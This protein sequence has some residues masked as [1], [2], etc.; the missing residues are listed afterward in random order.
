VSSADDQQERLI[1]LGWVI[2]FVDG[3]GCFS[4]GVV[5]QPRRTG[6]TGYKTGYQ[7]FHEFAVTQGE[8]SLG[9]LA[10]LR[11]FFGVGSVVANIRHD[12][13][14]E[15][16]HRY[17]VPRRSDLLAVVIP[18]FREHPLRSAKRLDFEKFADC[19]E[20]MSRGD[21]LSWEGLAEIV[22]VVE[23]MNRRKPRTELVRILRDHT[24]DPETS[25]EDMVPSAW[26][27]AGRRVA[28]AS[29]QA[30]LFG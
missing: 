30:S 22:E 3:E 29:A 23:T 4:I 25:G 13:H 21:H 19:V 26:R 7:M 10:D 15:D 18:F 5:R 16:V 11:N 8:K 14:R 6:R 9:C 1:S 2:G 24:P 27:H 28:G 12:N 20:R 17:V